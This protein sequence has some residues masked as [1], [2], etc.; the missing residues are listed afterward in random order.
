[1]NRLLRAPRT[2]DTTLTRVAVTGNSGLG[3]HPTDPDAHHAEDH[4]T[5]HIAGGADPFGFGH[6]INLD[7]IRFGHAGGPLLNG[8]GSGTILVLTGDLRVN[9]G[10]LGIGVAPP[11]TDGGLRAIAAGFGADPSAGQRLVI[12]PR[13]STDGEELV[14]ITGNISHVGASATSWGLRTNINSTGGQVYA[15][16]L[17]MDFLVQHVG[18]ANIG[19]L[20]GALMR[21][22][23]N[24]PA[25]TTDRVTAFEGR[26]RMFQGGTLGGPR[27]LAIEG[28]RILHNWGP[29]AVKSYTDTYHGFRIQMFDTNDKGRVEQVNILSLQEAI[30]FPKNDAEQTLGLDT[31]AEA[32]IKKFRWINQDS[33]HGYNL[34][35]AATKIPNQV[36]FDLRAIGDSTA[37]IDVRRTTKN[38]AKT[39]NLATTGDLVMFSDDHDSASD[40]NFK[41]EVTTGGAFSAAVWRWSNDNGS[42]WVEENLSMVDAD[43]IPINRLLQNG[44]EV[45]FRQGNY[46]ALDNWTW[47]A[48][49]TGNQLSVLRVDSKNEE[50]YIRSR[51][52]ILGGAVDVVIDTR[53]DGDAAP[54]FAMTT[55]GTMNWGDGTNPADVALARYAAGVLGLAAGN[56]FRADTA[57]HDTIN[58]RTPAAGVAVD[59]LVIKDGGIHD[60]DEDTSIWVEK[61]A[62]E[63]IVRVGTAG[64]ERVRWE[65]NGDMQ[66]NFI[67]MLDVGAAMVQA[68]APSTPADGQ[69]WLDTAAS[70]T[71]GLGVLNVTTITSNATLTTSQ[72]VVL[73]DASSGAITVTLP[74]ASGNDGRHYHIKKIDSSGN[75][76]TIDGNGSETIDGETTQAIAVQY[77]S[78]QL[79]C[80]G[81]VW[82]IL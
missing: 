2:G 48:I 8:P 14:R 30:P 75:A 21:C 81:S 54:R 71:G 79:V 39:L 26:T 6:T 41:V 10:S 13:G 69:L 77:N 20:V 27:L 61:A 57:E 22:D 58:E 65:A 59:G 19:Q 38:F 17:G 9:G 60:A 35:A 28:L 47:T 31:G 16:L 32:L 56:T 63:D 50:V 67:K 78:I 37:E 15:A 62:D 76:V 43:G 11:A 74:A 72:T 64:V 3:S 4:I 51:L 49:A 82:H 45:R 36:T 33:P 80:D 55:P 40:I 23:W 5:R 42:T 70:G 1:M 44:F 68:T 25:Y 29:G 66:G 24:S 12:T 53:I 34:L 18:S 73:C 46:T 52:N 7:Q